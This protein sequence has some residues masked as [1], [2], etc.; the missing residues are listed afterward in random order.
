MSEAQYVTR[1][2]DRVSFLHMLAY[3][4]GAFANN[5]LAGALGGLMVVLNLG[6]GMDPI[7]VGLLGMFPRFFD[8]F[9]DP[10]I[11][12]ISDNTRSRWGSRRPFI[13]IGAI[14]CCHHWCAGSQIK[15]TLTFV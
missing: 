4:S 10:I 15:N 14:L 5:L 11:G 9:T 3:G 13:F 8:A 6:L 7:L 1:P 2:E 12:Y